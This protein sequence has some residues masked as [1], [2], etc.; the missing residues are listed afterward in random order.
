VLPGLIG[1]RVN[2]PGGFLLLVCCREATSDQPGNAAEMQAEG[3]LAAAF[4]LSA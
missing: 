2:R 4:S 1:C 3:G